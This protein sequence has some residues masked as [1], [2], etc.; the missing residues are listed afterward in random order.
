M[1]EVVYPGSFDPVTNG[2]VDIVRR[3]ARI[4]GRVVVA[5]ASNVRKAGLFTTQERVEMLRE[6]LD[7]IPGVT[8][9]SFDG[10]LVD[11]LD[12]ISARVVIRG[13]RAVSDY[14]F[15]FQMAH[16]NRQLRPGVETVF[17]VAGSEEFF[18]SSTAVKE[19]AC[20]G[21]SVEQFVPPN[22]ARRLR[23]RFPQPRS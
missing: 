8:V 6:A 19:V 15:E 13:V 22:V 5:V 3:A 11:Y 14:E 7:G 21:G 16:M 20:F 12:R 1:T 18:I 17:L 10:L 23:E 4:F 9:D 2:H